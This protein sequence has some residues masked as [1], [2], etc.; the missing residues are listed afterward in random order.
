MFHVGW[1]IV[2]YQFRQIYMTH[3][4][5]NGE[6]GEHINGTKKC[7]IEHIHSSWH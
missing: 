2:G 6:G 4:F 5:S 7:P 3:Y 1:L